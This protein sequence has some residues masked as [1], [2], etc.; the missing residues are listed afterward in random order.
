MFPRLEASAPRAEAGLG[1]LGNKAPSYCSSDSPLWPGTTHSAGYQQLPGSPGNGGIGCTVGPEF[2]TAE[3]SRCDVSIPSALSAAGH[4]TKGADA[5]EHPRVSGFFAGRSLNSHWPVLAE[6]RK[7]LAELRR[8]R[9]SFVGDRMSV[10]SDMLDQSQPELIQEDR[11]LTK[12]ICAGTEVTRVGSEMRSLGPLRP[13][14]P[15]GRRP[16]TQIARR[17]VLQVNQRSE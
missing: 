5:T 17:A 2:M 10:V 14:L 3:R 16:P 13:S 15:N 6:S 8:V 11:C 9:P 12:V 1:T 4:P 7:S